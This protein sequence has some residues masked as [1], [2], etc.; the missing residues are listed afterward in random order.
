[1]RE[2]GPGRPE[3]LKGHPSSFKDV[4]PPGYG[5]HPKKTGGEDDPALLMEKLKENPS[6]DE[7]FDALKKM[8]PR[9]IPWILGEV[10]REPFRNGTGRPSWQSR[11]VILLSEMGPPALPYLEAAL[12]DRNE[13]VRLVS[14][15]A[16]ASMGKAAAPALASLERAA[17]DSDVRVRLAARGILMHLEPRGPAPLGPPVKGED[18]K[19]RESHRR[20]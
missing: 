5:T 7:A 19:G 11:A 1:M 17:R 20:K 13:K 10:R 4:S 8:G 2:P 16:L 3:P 6:G 9:V 12:G 14:V 15:L 18:E